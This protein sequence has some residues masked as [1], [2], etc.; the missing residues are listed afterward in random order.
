M[1]CFCCE[2]QAPSGNYFSSER[3][4]WSHCMQSKWDKVWKSCLG[5]E[6]P[7]ISLLRDN[8]HTNSLTRSWMWILQIAYSVG[9]RSRPNNCGMCRSLTFNLVPTGI[10]HHLCIERQ[11]SFRLQH[12]YSWKEPEWIT[13]S[14]V[15]P[16]NEVFY[17]FLTSH[18]EI[19][20]AE[21]SLPPSQTN[22]E[23]HQLHKD[24]AVLLHSR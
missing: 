23:V 12:Q 13:Y 14:I 2:Q 9:F 17:S 11:K 6:H 1:S 8:S 4:W 10:I 21:N 24:T 19:A 15:F 18:W 20:V 7:N 16:Q 22:P 3:V 5:P